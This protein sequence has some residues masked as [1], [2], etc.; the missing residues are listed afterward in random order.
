LVDGGEGFGIFCPLCDI[1]DENA[2]LQSRLKVYEDMY[3]SCKP[4]MEVK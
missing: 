2:K 1:R 3:N 4:A